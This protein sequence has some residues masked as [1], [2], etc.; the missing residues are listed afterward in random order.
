VTALYAIGAALALGIAGFAAHELRA[1]WRT[2]GASADVRRAREADARARA[3]ADDALARAGHAVDAADA[4]AAQEVD[5]A[6]RSGLAG[7]L[8][9]RGAGDR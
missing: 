1:W 4:R 6:R 2:R 7:W 8:R 9:G 3:A 5:D